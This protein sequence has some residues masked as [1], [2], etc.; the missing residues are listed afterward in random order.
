MDVSQ[1]I[2]QLK[3]MPQDAI[4]VSAEDPDGAWTLLSK[5]ILKRYMGAPVCVLKEGI[6]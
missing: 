5:A 2:E 4:V 6:Y 1:L 3:T